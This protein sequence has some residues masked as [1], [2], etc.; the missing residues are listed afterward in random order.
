MMLVAFT[1]TG[2]ASASKPGSPL[3]QLPVRIEQITAFGGR[4]DISP[5]NQEIAFIGK[6]FGM[7]TF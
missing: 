4:A 5:D 6:S 7:S 2:A 1:V 3:D